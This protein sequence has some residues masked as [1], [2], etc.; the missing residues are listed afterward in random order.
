MH[1]IAAGAFALSLGGGAF[2]ADQKPQEQSQNQNP[3]GQ[4]TD[5]ADQSKRD[6]E[7]LAALK[8]CQNQQG[9]AKQKCVD[10]AKQKYD[11][12]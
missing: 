4:A 8:K 6:Q 7:Y 12:M 3:Q 11:R 10:E 1:I 5:P 9:D 2:A